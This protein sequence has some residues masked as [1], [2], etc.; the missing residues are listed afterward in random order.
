LILFWWCFILVWPKMVC[1]S[2][3]SKW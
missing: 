2:I 3:Y 1:A